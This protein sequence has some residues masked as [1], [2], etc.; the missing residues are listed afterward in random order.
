MY[1]NYPNTDVCAGIPKVGIWQVEYC[2]A[3]DAHAIAVISPPTLATLK[4]STPAS[5]PYLA[6]FSR[7][8]SIDILRDARRCCG[9]VRR[10]KC[11]SH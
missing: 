9:C 4:D 6:S 1:Q 3:A 8:D 10:V 7:N 2:R 5:S 11:V